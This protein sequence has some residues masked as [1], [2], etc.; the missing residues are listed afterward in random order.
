GTFVEFFNPE[1]GKLPSSHV[2][3]IAMDEAGKLWV[4]NFRAGLVRL[5]PATGETKVYTPEN[6]ALTHAEILELVV[7]PVGDIVVGAQDAGLNIFDPRTETFT[8]Y[9]ND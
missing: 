8:I 9:R 3:D 5:D 1:N 4:N 6:S 7:T 2:F